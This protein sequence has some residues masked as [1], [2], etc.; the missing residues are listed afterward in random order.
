MKTARAHKKIYPVIIEQDDNGFFIGSVPTL[1][2][3]YTQGTSIEEVIR[4]LETE[5]IPLCEAHL[6]TEDEPVL[7]YLE[8][9]EIAV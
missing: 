8:I 6:A 2:S 1:P 5:V 9:R 7:E 4:L 3:C